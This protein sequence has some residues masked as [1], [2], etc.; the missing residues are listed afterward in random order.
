MR[1]D[2]AHPTA[3]LLKVEIDGVIQKA[4]KI[5]EPEITEAPAPSE[6][7]KESALSRS[8]KAARG[9]RCRSGNPQGNRRA[10]KAA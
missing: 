8:P 4:S 10:G 1:G 9:H 7:A 3:K 2:R 5:V 6:H